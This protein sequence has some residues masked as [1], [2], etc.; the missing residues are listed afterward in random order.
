[1]WTLVPQPRIKPAPP[2]LKQWSLHYW[3]TREVS[4]LLSFYTLASIQVWK[5]AIHT[6][7]CRDFSKWKSI[8]ITHKIDGMVY[9]PVSGF[10]VP[11]H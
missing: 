1:M 7:M 11:T 2:A 8:V 4:F 10:M 5:L 3:T 9:I 6:Q